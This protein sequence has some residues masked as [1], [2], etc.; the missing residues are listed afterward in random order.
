VNFLAQQ[1][2]GL[3]VLRIRKIPHAQFDQQLN[4]S[5]PNM[6][7]NWDGK[8][9]ECYRLY[10]EEKR[11]LDE[12]AEYWDQRGFAPRYV[13]ALLAVWHAV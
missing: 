3:K 4:T 8:E 1:T 5:T 10:V 7:Y 2:S 6:V 12:V 9:A 13:F 11:S